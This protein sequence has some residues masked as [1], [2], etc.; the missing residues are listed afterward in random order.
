MQVQVSSKDHLT[1]RDILLA[2]VFKFHIYYQTRKIL[3]EMSCPIPGESIF[4]TI[5]NN[6]NMIKYQKLCNEFGIRNDTNFR[7]K[8]GDNR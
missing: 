6:I 7:F 1:A 4:K 3:E 8:G 2:S 5:D